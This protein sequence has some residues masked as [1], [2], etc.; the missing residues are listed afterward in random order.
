MVLVWCFLIFLLAGETSPLAD[1]QDLENLIF[2]IATRHDVNPTLFRNIAKC[3]SG[4]RVDAKNSISS[5]SGIMQFLT[6]TFISQANAYGLP[7]DNKND[8]KIQLELAARMIANGG[9]SH[10]SESKSCWDK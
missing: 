8:A 9:I 3:E 6:S 5:A 4:L 10:W 2:A 1:E 7:T